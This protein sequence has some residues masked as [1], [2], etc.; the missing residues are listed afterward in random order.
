L[1]DRGLL[2]C[3]G[4]GITRTVGKATAGALRLWQYRQKLRGQR[5]GN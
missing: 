5:H 3:H 1:V 2:V 4:M